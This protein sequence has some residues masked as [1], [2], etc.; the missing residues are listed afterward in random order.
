MFDPL[1]SPL[2]TGRRTLANHDI[3]ASMSRNKARHQGA[4]PNALWRT[5][6][7]GAEPSEC[8][9]YKAARGE[10]ILAAFLVADIGHDALP[11]IGN[12]AQAYGPASGHIDYLTSGQFTSA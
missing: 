10:M 1:L 4:T 2:K 9:N 8:S 7:D 12:P 6:R 3:A 5:Q 11:A